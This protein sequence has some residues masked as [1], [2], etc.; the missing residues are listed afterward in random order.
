MT[1]NIDDK[2]KQK[3]ADEES[4]PNNTTCQKI[5]KDRSAA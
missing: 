2:N 1:M 3:S 5:E 4:Q